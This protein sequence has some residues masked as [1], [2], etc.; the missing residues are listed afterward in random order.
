[1]ILQG[2][3]NA[4]E[5]GG[6][7]VVES[8]FKIKAT[9]KAFK[10]LS[11]GLYSDKPLAVVR[12]LCCN[13]YDAHVAAGRKE[14]PFTVHL[15]SY[16]EPYFS[17]R[18]DGVGLSRDQV[19]NIFTTYFES[20]KSNSNDFI[21]ALG[22]GSKSPFSYVDSFTVVSRYDGKKYSFN[23]FMTEN[24]IPAIALLMEEDTTERNGVEITMPVRQSDFGTFASKASVV[25]EWFDPKPVITGIPELNFP[26]RKIGV[27]GN[28][29][30]LTTSGGYSYGY[31]QR[32]SFMAVQ[33]RIAYPVV[34]DAMRPHASQ[35]QMAILENGFIVQF[36]IGDLEIAA[37]REQLSFKPTTIAN[38]L[39]KVDRII[40][41]LPAK[42]QSS[43]DECGSYWDA[44]IKLQE[45]TS[46]YPVVR[47]LVDYSGGSICLWQG[48]KIATGYI[49]F[50]FSEL[51]GL[52]I[53]TYSGR[54]TSRTVA[55]NQTNQDA[56]FHITPDKDIQFVVNDLP[57]GG[58][59]RTK[60]NA[61]TTNKQTYLLACDDQA[62][63]ETFIDKLG[64]PS[65]C[66]KA[67]S[68][69]AP[70]VS[71]RIT[72]ASIQVLKKA[73]DGKLVFE[74]PTDD[75]EVGDGGFYIPLLR[76]KPDS[77]SLFFDII[78]DARKLG[79]LASDEL[80][81]G[82]TRA[83]LPKIEKHEGW[84]N[85]LDT[86]KERFNTW[87]DENK[88]ADELSF[89]QNFNRWSGDMGWSH[90]WIK[91][92]NSDSIKILGE[93]HKVSVFYKEIENAQAVSIDTVV[94][95]ASQL[96][97]DASVSGGTSR[98][99]F[100]GSWEVIMEEYPMIKYGIRVDKAEELEPLLIYFKICDS[101][102]S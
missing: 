4:I 83:I 20:T 2:S 7:D 77:T 3:N 76:G 57:R 14:V 51:P 41:E 101:A 88:V 39:K 25:L 37:S 74:S 67:S 48:R 95:L 18:D 56:C 32:N 49:R 66:V 61:R 98:F 43:I 68:F 36:E 28:G 100:V 21:G 52:V 60:T 26:T 55:D 93:D 35:M 73:W 16:V 50:P 8:Q 10:I 38:I 81:Y 42:F 19:E 94:A 85:I 30:K 23:A 45:F 44:C 62:V 92:L 12:E 22:L 58:A 89:R 13:A 72:K 87:V 102:A 70:P 27:E 6:D 78:K 15:P 59:G 96:G 1:M 5:R 71:A 53:T 97:A 80:V 79:I 17:V 54:S 82:V 33:G 11:D 40:E 24:D 46:S 65:N 86:I 63:I 64:N 29:W 9:G 31:Y 90:Y 34:L 84:E 69:P 99:D 47:S 91:Q 75:V